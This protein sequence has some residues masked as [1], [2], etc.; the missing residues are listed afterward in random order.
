MLQRGISNKNRQMHNTEQHVR[1]YLRAIGERD[2]ALARKKL[3]DKGFSYKSPIGDYDDADRFIQSISALGAILEDV[4]IRR[5]FTS[6]N[7][8]MAIVDTRI[9][10]HGYVTRTI[11]MLFRVEN[12]RITA[13][14]VIFDASQYHKMFSA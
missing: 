3:A 12:E 4:A 5:L 9:S 13:L 1:S 7:E 2:F 11:A 6:G 8:A 10:L 14:E